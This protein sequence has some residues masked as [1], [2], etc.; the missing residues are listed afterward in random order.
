MKRVGIVSCKFGSGAAST[1]GESHLEFYLSVAKAITNEPV[2]PVQA[3]PLARMA[4][5]NERLNARPGAVGDAIAKRCSEVAKCAEVIVVDLDVPEMANIRGSAHINAYAAINL[6]LQTTHKP[7]QSRALM[8]ILLVPELPD[9]NSSSMRLLN[10]DLAKGNIVLI[11]DAGKILPEEISRPS[12]NKEQYRLKLSEIRGKPIELLRHKLVRQRGHFKR[13]VNGVHTECVPLYFD[14]RLCSVEVRKLV[15]DYVLQNYPGGARPHFIYRPDY[16]NWLE[17]LLH[18]LAGEIGAE[19]HRVWEVLERPE[20]GDD[21]DVCAPL[22]IVQL[23]DS[24][25]SL[26]EVRNQVCSKF[27]LDEIKCLA[28]LSTT[29]NEPCFGSRLVEGAEIAYFLKVPQIRQL[30]ADCPMCR[31]DLPYSKEGH[32][33]NLMLTSYEFWTM[34]DI[35]GLKK[36]DDPPPYRMKLEAVP[37]F[38]RILD[39]NGAWI[40]SKIGDL[41]KNVTGQL[42]NDIV[43]VCPDQ[44][45][46]QVLTEYLHLVSGVTVIRIRDEDIRSAKD[47]NTPDSLIDEWERTQPEWYMQIRAA[48]TQKVVVLDEFC[49][50]AVK[51]DALHTVMGQLK[52]TVV[53]YFALADFCPQLAEKSS[54]PVMSLYEWRM[55]GGA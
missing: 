46:S 1:L 32:D 10:P 37:D 22:L 12:F 19:C 44:K 36:E 53:C 48:A 5:T 31:L 51:R 4:I 52:K 47:L 3:P 29:G 20:L 49:V 7:E 18:I 21:F 34:V 33:D 6:A 24:G 30:V 26:T 25:N 14:G 8:L 35:A 17:G 55:Y 38:P 11:S 15:H 23:I 42:P 27:Q 39:S 13:F 2:T 41:L 40:A 16:S 9:S 54:I 43:V 45:G 50:S 28:V